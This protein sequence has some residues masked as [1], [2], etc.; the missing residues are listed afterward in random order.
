[1][2]TIRKTVTIPANHKLHMDLD[3]PERVP[4]GEADV[5]LVIS[6][7]NGG[8][9]AAGLGAL[10]GCLADSPTFS[11]DPVRLQKEL[12]DEWD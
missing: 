7:R 5:V 2:D 9:R 1:M 12:R 6:P 10:A 4:A 3:I 11:R 8:A